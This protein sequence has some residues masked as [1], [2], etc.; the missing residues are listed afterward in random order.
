[1]KRL[2][3]L[4]TAFS[5]ALAACG[6]AP[7]NDPIYRALKANPPTEI[8]ARHLAKLRR[9]IVSCDVYNE[10]QASQYMT[11]WWTSGLPPQGAYLTY[12]GPATPSPSPTRITAPGGTRVFSGY[13][14]I[15]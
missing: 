2:L 11:C 7:E 14:P 5:L 8:P 9:G 1:M 13:L 6:P 10:N 12:Y 3:P 15:K 4:G